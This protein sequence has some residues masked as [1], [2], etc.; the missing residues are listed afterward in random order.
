MHSPI[1]EK[2][3]VAGRFSGVK[4][5]PSE[6]YKTRFLANVESWENETHNFVVVV[7]IEK[8]EEGRALLEGGLTASEV[9]SLPIYDFN[10]GDAY[11][12]YLDPKDAEKIKT[13][14]KS[15]MRLPN[16]CHCDQ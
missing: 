9:E 8:L 16:F 2:G 10:G 6:P 3:G 5:I 7:K 1:M 15:D 4:T 12:T 13:E 11:W 14:T